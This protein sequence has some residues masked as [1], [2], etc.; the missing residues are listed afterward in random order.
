MNQL[1]AAVSVTAQRRLRGGSEEAQHRPDEG[2]R[3]HMMYRLHL[4]SYGL[5]TQGNKVTEWPGV[6]PQWLMSVHLS[7]MT[8]K[9][10]ARITNRE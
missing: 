4:S 5:Y 8:V 3:V 1:C 7:G 9:G 6:E 10:A 2:T